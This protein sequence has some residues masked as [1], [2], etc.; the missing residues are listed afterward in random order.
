MIRFHK[1]FLPIVCVSMLSLSLMGCSKE[2]KEPKEIDGKVTIYLTRHGETQYNVEGLAQGWSDSP[3]TTDGLTQANSL[4]SGLK[5]V[6]FANV[7][8]SPSGRA[9]QTATILSEGRH[10]EIIEDERLKEMNFGSLEANPNERLWAKGEDYVWEHG[11]V[12]YGG[13]DFTM[14]ATRGMEAMNDI[15]MNP[16][17]LN[18]NVLVS[19]HGMTILS[20]LYEIDYEA[21][22]SLAQG[23]ANCS[24][25][26]VVYENGIYTLETLNDTSYL[27]M[28]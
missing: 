11:W 8:S 14:L 10:L 25:T 22:D 4:K 17:N 9:I 1:I 16:G 15:I 7:Y 5:D 6:E 18:K 27:E 12:D 21:A 13:E 28:E 2:T 23:L 20:L 24:I 3:L 19:T 26:K